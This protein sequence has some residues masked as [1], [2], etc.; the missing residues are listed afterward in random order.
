M[1]L[2]RLLFRK[3]FAPSPVP[4]ISSAKA[5]CAR[6]TEDTVETST[7][8]VLLLRLQLTSEAG[9]S[10]FGQLQTFFCVE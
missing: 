9:N 8:V 4:A 3:V 5:L 7:D 10:A 6:R 2:S 1:W